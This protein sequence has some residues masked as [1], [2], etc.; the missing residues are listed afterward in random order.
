[1]SHPISDRWL[2]LGVGVGLILAVKGIRYAIKDTLRLTQV[3]PLGKDH[4][5]EL[6]RQPEDC[7]SANHSTC[8]LLRRSEMANDSPQQS[9][10]TPYAPSSTHQT[11]T[12][13]KTP[14][15]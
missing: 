5:E 4:D 12:S 10:S 11:P 13:A 2:W 6:S 8:K 14:P 3:Q 7:T 1:M 9:L 15:T